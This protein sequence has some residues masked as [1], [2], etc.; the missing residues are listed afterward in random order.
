[1]GRIQDSVARSEAQGQEKAPSLIGASQKGQKGRNGRNGQNGRNAKANGHVALPESLP[2]TQP[3]GQF[4]FTSYSLNSAPA[5]VHVESLPLEE[6][7]R[8]ARHEPVREVTLDTRRLD[9]HLVTL[10]GVLNDPER[11]A[12]CSCNEKI[13]IGSILKAQTKGS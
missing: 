3:K 5:E 11:K 9:P 4:D 10:T 13:A 8:R 7:L 1:M 12:A 2:G 6:A